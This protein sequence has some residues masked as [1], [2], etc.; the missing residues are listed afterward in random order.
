MIPT[1]FIIGAGLGGLSAAMYLASHGFKVTVFEKNARVG[2]KMQEFRSKT[3][4]HFDAG[5]TLLTMP[6]VF[7]D[8]FQSVGRHLEDYLTL[9]PLKTSCKY[10]FPDGTTFNAY[11]NKGK[12][13]QEIRTVFPGLEPSF[14]EYLNY[15]KKIYAATA[16]SFIYNPLTFWRLIR[17]NPLDFLAIDA[18]STAHEANSRFFADA[19]FVQFL[20]RFPTYVGSSPYLAPATLNVIP[21]VELTFG[22]HYV[23]GGIYQLAK[24]YQKVCAELGV[25][26]CFNTE[27]TEIL[28][29]ENQASGVRL[30]NGES[31]FCDAI[32]SND[33]AVHTYQQLVNQSSREI[34][35]E[36]IFRRWEAS[37]SGFVLCLGV[38]A[39]HPE[40]SH[41][42]IFFSSNYEHEFDEI[43]TQKVPPTDP[44]IYISISAKS[45]AAQA[46]D[47]AENW[48][49]LVNAPYLTEKF[50]WE[51]EKKSYR[52]LIM[53]RLKQLGF[54][55]LEEQIEFEQ[56]LTPKDLQTRFNAN[57]GSIYGISSNSRSAAFLRPANR[58]PYVKG[59]YLASGSSHPGGGTPMV[60]LSGKFAA[61]LLM[62]DFL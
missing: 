26:F 54:K 12:L 24:A 34:I 57:L 8:L 4:Y 5:P 32:V 28:L 55:K 40:L 2:G 53:N 17:Q 42:N 41:H 56:I 38:K 39:S 33:D 37:C 15:T 3:G 62:E 29:K 13:F 46:P 52:N 30:K 1:V 18:F 10:F 27:V 45:D 44:T 51:K 11:T 50:D 58:S 9:T 35:S 25:R 61:D 31:H 48:F 7:R 36:T 21:H 60:T 20:D 19:R 23:Q 16:Q 6:F 47:G 22:A 59:L 49:V 14:R 43:F